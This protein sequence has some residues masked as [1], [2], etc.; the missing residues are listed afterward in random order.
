MSP[1][2]MAGASRSMRRAS[3]L[4]LL[5]SPWPLARWKGSA[6]SRSPPGGRSSP[7]DAKDTDEP[8]C[9]PPPKTLWERERESAL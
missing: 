4:L 6:A 7:S 9:P 5:L 8:V 1:S 2:S 3:T